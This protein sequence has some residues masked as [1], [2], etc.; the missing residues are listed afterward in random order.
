MT[1][2]VFIPCSQKEFFIKFREI[3]LG[4]SELH[5]DDMW[6][7]EPVGNMRKQMIGFNILFFT[8]EAYLTY[9]L[10]RGE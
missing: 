10:F 8:E 6:K 9:Q 7:I 2:T 5:M 1:E 4:L 3:K